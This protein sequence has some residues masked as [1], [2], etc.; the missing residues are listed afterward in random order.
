MLF[1]TTL[2]AFGQDQSQKMKPEMTEIW[3]PEVQIV[4][5]AKT[6]SMLPPPSDAIILFDGK[7]LSK[8]SNKKGGS[9]LWTVNGGVF[10]VKKGT[11]DIRSIQEFEDFQLHIEWLVPKNI[12]GSGQSRGNSGIFLQ[13]RYELQVLDSYNNRTYSNGQAGSIYKQYPPL[14]NAMTPPGE[15][16][17]YDIIYTAPRFNDNGTLFSPAR[18]TVLHNGILI[19][20]NV[21]IQGNT[22]YIGLPKYSPHGKGPIVLQDHGDPSEPVSFRNIW[23]REL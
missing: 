6:S 11:G 3:L 19:Q 9:A 5:P 18:V 10:T 12:S 7:D 21:Q 17:V 20:N 13:G 1:F 14:K 2:K 16:N 22:E 4:N 8:W 15:W 23:I